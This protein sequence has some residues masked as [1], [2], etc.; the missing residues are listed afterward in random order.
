MTEL[1]RAREAGLAL[2]IL[3]VVGATTVHNHD[4]VNDQSIQQLLS[5]AA[6][7][8]LLGVGETLV[9]V[10][11]NVDLSVGSVLGLSAYVVGDLFREDHIPV[12]S[13]FVI[14]IAVG[15][16]AGALNGFIVTVLRVPSLVITLAMLYVIRGVDSLFVNGNTVDASSVPSAFTAI[17]YRTILGVPWLAVIVTVI[18]AAT[19]YAMRSFRSSRELYA[20]GSNPDAAVLAGVP[21]GRRVFLAFLTSGTLAGLAGALFLA[22]HAQVD[23]SAG[24]G[25][26]LTVVAAAVVGGVAIFG[27]SGTVVGAALGALLL[28]TINQAL[29][30]SRISAFWNEAI[31][32]ALHLV[33]I[34]FDRYLYLRTG[35]GPS[36]TTEA[37]GAAA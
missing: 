33:A 22:L 9:M 11:R 10:T 7:I 21:V 27:G 2:L 4:F 24:F 34:A 18:V 23:N 37:H 36:R 28:N 8:A 30:A 25:Y 35:S 12:W 17:G 16:V 20:I 31:A 26:E 15:A 5:G 6:L 32:G 19:G 29:V 3:V 1:L 14:G 13:G